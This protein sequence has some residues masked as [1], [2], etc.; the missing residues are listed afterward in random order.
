MFLPFS[1]SQGFLLVAVCLRDGCVTPPCLFYFVTES[2]LPWELNGIIFEKGW[3][4]CWTEELSLWVAVNALLRNFCFIFTV[5]WIWMQHPVVCFVFNASVV[6]ASS[7][8]PDNFFS[9]LIKTWPLLNLFLCSCCLSAPLFTQVQ[10]YFYNSF[11]GL[12]HHA[13]FSVVP[14]YDLILR[15]SS[16]LSLQSIGAQELHHRCHYVKRIWKLDPG[17]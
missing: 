15:E 3:T 11:N 14:V 12:S 10:L 5:L 1:A 8:V 7:F 13:H 2:V 4:W 9:F 16:D 17:E 6:P